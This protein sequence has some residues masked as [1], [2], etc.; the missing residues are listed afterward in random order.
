MLIPILNL[1]I[2]RGF[3]QTR[4]F[5][6]WCRT[7]ENFAKSLKFKIP[8]SKNNTGNGVTQFVCPSLALQSSKVQGLDKSSGN[9]VVT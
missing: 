4:F 7:K 2:F 8:M 1:T 5:T 6:N 3:K 9:T